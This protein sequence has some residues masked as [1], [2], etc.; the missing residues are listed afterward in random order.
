MIFWPCIAGVDPE[1]QNGWIIYKRLGNTRQHYLFTALY[2]SMIPKIDTLTNTSIASTDKGSF[3]ATAEKP[4]GWRETTLG[5]IV[6][7]AQ[8]VAINAKTNHVL[9]DEHE[10]LPLLKINNLLNNTVDQYANPK[11]VPQKA[12]LEID[13]VI[14]TR[15]GQ[16]G[17]VFT[18]KRGILHNN[19]FKVIPSELLNKKFLYWFLKQQ[20]IYDYVQKVASGSAQ[21]DLN[22]DAF[23]TISI[24]LPPLPEQVAIASVL[25]SFDDKIELLREQN[26]TLEALGQTIFQE[27][28]GKYSVDGELPEGWRIGKLGEVIENFDS[29]RIPIASDKREKWPYPYYWATWINDYVQDYIFDWI[30]TLLW[31]DWSVIKENWRPFTQYVWWKIWVN[32]HA[33]VLQGKNWFSTELIKVILDNTDIAPYVNGAVQLKINQTNMNAIPVIIPDQETLKQ[34]DKAI[35]PIFSKIRDNSE[36]IKSLS[37]SRHTLLPKLMSGEVRVE[38]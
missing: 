4:A 9:C 26:Q 2:L 13:D 37:T 8:W 36:Q 1:G 6:E 30:Y 11:V 29:Q 28:F 15:T 7:L 27:W 5:E 24:S 31:E 38:F 17:W 23:K 14:F 21:P 32:N 20:S 34:F 10:W 18:G 16:V 22:H 3:S 33:H 19:S 25:S 35:Q 12:I